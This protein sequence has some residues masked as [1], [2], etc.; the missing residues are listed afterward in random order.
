MYNCSLRLDRLFHLQ[1]LAQLSQ[2]CQISKENAEVAERLNQSRP[3][4]FH[5]QMRHR[6]ELWIDF[7]YHWRCYM[8]SWRDVIDQT[9]RRS[10]AGMEVGGGMERVS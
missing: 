9:R 1:L 3:N 7:F 4:L 6:V 10:H 8:G 5:K 2:I